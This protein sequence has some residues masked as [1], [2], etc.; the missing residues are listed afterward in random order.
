M[1]E[2]VMG[3]ENYVRLYDGWFY[4][5][6]FTIMRIG[7]NGDI[8]IS[9]FKTRVSMPANVQKNLPREA[10]KCNLYL[11]SFRLPD[12]LPNGK[13]FVVGCWFLIKKTNRSGLN[14]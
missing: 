14:R 1:I 10:A 2:M 12:Y 3:Y 4:P 13:N 7:N 8:I 9:N 5:D 11:N 6:G